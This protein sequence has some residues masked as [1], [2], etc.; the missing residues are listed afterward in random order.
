MTLREP[1]PRYALLAVFVMAGV[2][3][4]SAVFAQGPAL[5]TVHG[6]VLTKSEDPI[7]EAIVFLKNL[8]NG[9]VKSY[10]SESSG[11]YR[12]SGLDPNVDYEIH[13]EFKGD[14]S[15]VRRLSSLDNRK[16]IYLNLIIVHKK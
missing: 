16:D 13:A 4:A 7:S 5:K 6:S 1:A 14:S 8:Q 12:F 11:S 10:I 2:L 9:A 3:A 15:A